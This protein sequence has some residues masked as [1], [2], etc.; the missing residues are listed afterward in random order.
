[1]MAYSDMFASVAKY[2]TD[3]VDYVRP[4]EVYV[5]IDGVA[6]AAKMAQQRERRFK[7]VKEA[8]AKHEIAV[9]MGA[10][11]NEEQI[12]FNMIS[13][14]TEFM[15][16]LEDY[17]T[18]FIA[19]RRQPSG[20]WSHIKFSL[21][22]S[23][24]AGEGEHK[25]MS[26]IR[27]RGR[28]PDHTN[29]IY[30]LDADL[31]FLGLENDP[32]CY[33]VR[34]NVHFSG[35][36]DLGMD[37]AVYPYIFL[38]IGG[39]RDK[40]VSILD[41]LCGLGHL[42]QMGFEYS[43]PDTP[44]P[45]QVASTARH[46]K[47]HGHPKGRGHQGH[48]HG[49]GNGHGRGH[50]GDG[51]GALASMTQSSW[52][53]TDYHRRFIRDYIYICFLLGNDF[54]PRL[55]CLKIRNG[56]LNNLIV[57]YKQTAWKHNSYLVN[58]DLTL[59]RQF[60]LDLI[61]SVSALEDSSMLKF[62]DKRQADITRF[63]HRNNSKPPY[64][65][66][67]EAF[68]YVEDQYEDTILGGTPGWRQRYYTYHLGMANDQYIGDICRGYLEGMSWVMG[69]Y[70]GQHNNW[71]WSYPYDIAPTAADLEVAL[72]RT[73][74]PTD[75]KFPADEPASPYIQ[76]LSI[77]P[78]DSARLLPP[79]LQAL[80]TDKDSP[81]HYM[82]PL[83]VTMSLVGN[84]FWHECR[85]RMPTVDRQAL[86]DAV[87]AKY[88]YLTSAERQRNGVGQVWRGIGAPTAVVKC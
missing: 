30:G 68:D 45:G 43:L 24:V 15:S 39:L 85:P 70:T 78:P 18:G 58:A 49:H 82:Y 16:G 65:R 7:S 36:D 57:L 87:D 80:M 54:L 56:S 67:I 77:L 22:G 23:S 31:I 69:Y 46:P 4:V 53:G 51:H 21:S 6:P 37:P 76:L 52:C 20:L 62:S 66:A 84:K 55:P 48:G 32:E 13:P 64:E 59:N 26:E 71:T 14:G 72:R 11:V 38:D 25:I 61:S 3:I 17:I 83:R 47:G 73:D 81:V 35:R 5:A 41:P 74:I 10:P 12:D 34:E 75:H 1:M 50:Q 27:Q 44:A 33:L 42:S 29:C 86:V 60:F 19:D 79:S 9:S 88:K 8:K 63:R 28:S 40:I 2:L